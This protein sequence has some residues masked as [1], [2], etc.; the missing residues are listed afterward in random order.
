MA[1][2]SFDEKAVF[3][4][5]LSR[6]GTDRDAY[7]RSVCPDNASRSRIE[8]LLQHHGKAN[9]DFLKVGFDDV[10]PTPPALKQLDEFKIIQRLGEG[11]MGVVYLA[12]DTILHR[13]VALKV[14]APQMTGSAQ[15][16]AR[17]GDEARSTAALNHPAIVPIYRFGQD[18]DW[19]YLVSEF[20]E[21]PTL[22]QFIERRRSSLKQAHTQDIRAWHR[23]VAQIA[24][25]IAD[26][27]DCAHRANIIHRDVKP[28]NILLDSNGSPRL[29]DF[30]IAKHLAEGAKEHTTLIGSCH[31]MSPEQ[32]GLI[33]DTIDRRSDIFSLGVVMYEMLALRRPFDGETM[34][35]VLKSVKEVD[36]PKLRLNDRRIPA[37]LETICFKALEKRPVDRYQSAAHFAADLRCYLSGVPILAS[38][39]SLFR[40]TKSFVVR[41]KRAVPIVAALVIGLLST[42]VLWEYDR[43]QRLLFAE[44]DV[45]CA[46]SG[47]DLIIE[48]YTATTTEPSSPRAIG[49]LPTT[50]RLKPGQ[51]RLIAYLDDDRFTEQ[52]L[53]ITSGG[54]QMH[55]DFPALRPDSDFANMV[56]F[57][58][59]PFDC[60]ENDL[61]FQTMKV[62]AKVRPFLIDAT[63]VSNAE[64][65]RFLVE[66]GHPAPNFWTEVGGYRPEWADLPASGMSW[67]DA[68]AYCAWAGKRLPTRAEWEF[69]MR[70]P[71]NRLLPWE[72]ETPVTRPS[73]SLYDC[74]LT[75]AG[76][77][78]VRFKAYLDAVVP[79]HSHPEL[80]TPTG[81]YHGASNVREFT[82]TVTRN[83]TNAV[84]IIGASFC[85]PPRIKNFS[86]PWTYP[87]EDTKG[88]GEIVHPG[89]LLLGFR[90][91]RSVA[92]PSRKEGDDE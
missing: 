8:S 51:Y 3:L 71:D 7:L 70:F 77:P 74:G 55:V 33:D 36:P 31:Y 60:G 21:G 61:G 83:A 16:L 26:A 79:V 87:L 14:L 6:S 19:H 18:G 53:L 38:P 63:E 4:E 22:S 24:A 67:Y 29:T 65:H 49:E 92:P 81:L 47:A 76:A 75:V 64:Y 11:G 59:G 56:R 37:D 1:D 12:K 57:E 43:Y 69:A 27:L 62:H 39:P 15:A 40:R 5:A 9:D 73:S 35:A 66:T 91:A 44:V 41:H 84:V 88:N 30:G 90:C 52:T 42:V 45:S 50:I 85:D 72:G 28:S 54:R 46:T 48:S 2:S 68:N 86:S 13:Q 20:V 89:S 78:E 58:G 25:T 32:A 34:Q 82:E 23:Q 10:R 80:A 17:F